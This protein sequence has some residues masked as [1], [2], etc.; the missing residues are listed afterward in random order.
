MNKLNTIQT[1]IIV[2]IFLLAVSIFCFGIPASAKPLKS[3]GDPTIAAGCNVYIV[4]GVNVYNF[5]ASGGSVTISVANPGLCAWTTK[6]SDPWV[7]LTPNS[8]ALLPISQVKITV[9]ANS[10]APRIA[11]ILFGSTPVLITINQHAPCVY[12]FDINSVALK[13]SESIHGIINVTALDPDCP[14]NATSNANWLTILNGNQGKG[15]GPIEYYVGMNSGPARTGKITL[16]NATFTVTQVASCTYTPSS[17][18]FSF[19]A[20]GGSSSLNVK[21]SSPACPWTPVS[22]ALWLKINNGFPQKMLGDGT[23]TLN[24]EPNSGT[25]RTATVTIDSKVITVNQAAGSVVCSFGISPGSY[26]FGAAGGEVSVNVSASQ[27]SCKWYINNASPFISVVTGGFGGVG[28]GAV[29][30]KVQPNAGAARAGSIEIAGK[31]FSVTQDG[32]NPATM[33][34]V[35]ISPGFASVGSKEF[36]LGVKGANFTSACKVRWNGKERPTTFYNNTVMVAAI[37]ASDIANEGAFSVTVSNPNNGDETN[38]EKFMVY[39]AVA[40]VSS[41]SFKGESLAPA[42]LVSAFGVD[43]ATELKIAD[44]QPLPTELAG[45]TV[46]V[47]DAAGQEHQTKLFFVSSG[48]INYLMPETV[49]LG[50]A[51]VIIQSGSGHT[52]VSTVEITQVAPA[53]FSANSTGQGVAT[54][55]V[56]RVKA[57]GQ[58]VYEQVAQ[59][60]APAGAFTAKP[61]DLSVPGEQVYLAFYGSGLRYRSML[62]SASVAIGGVSLNALYVGPAP[63]YE[64][65]DQVNILLPNSLAGRGD[66]DVLLSVDGKQSN[67]VKLR[68]K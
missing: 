26:N 18:S 31:T 15:N 55:I 64:G 9:A 67:T 28:N 40:N 14:R 44:S 27:S 61:I 24:V 68:I 6:V 25:A 63:G 33:M 20:S 57:N 34:L 8:G 54:A 43:L 50:R 37:P 10:G 53:L 41:A 30:L 62:S 42:S 66:V 47:T 65:L 35:G 11:T 16:G 51:T 58:Q 1:R 17:S 2:K 38:A 32:A 52:S 21:T 4:G 3:A 13:A 39:G 7:S 23:I 46:T 48:Q 60:D 12:G 59:Y 5:P 45:T 19:Q 29:K 56:V 49:S 36:L 22:S